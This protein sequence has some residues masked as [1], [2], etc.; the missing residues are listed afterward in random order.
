[1][2]KSLIL[3][4]ILFCTVVFAQKATLSADQVI[5]LVLKNKTKNYSKTALKSYQY[6]SYNK[7]VFSIDKTLIERKIDS[8]FEIKKSKKIFK[9]LDSTNYFFKKEMDKQHYYISE[10][11]AE[12]S[13]IDGREKENILAAKMAGFQEPI[14]EFLAL[15][16]TNISFY[17]N[18]FSLLGTNYVSPL[19]R[20]PFKDYQFSFDNY[21]DDDTKYIIKY[22]SINR[23][24]SIGL[25]GE[26]H[27]DKNTFALVRSKAKIIGKVNIFVVQNYEYLEN[28]NIWFP[29]KTT[30]FLRKGASKKSVK[31]FR[32]LIGYKTNYVSTKNINPEDVSYILINVNNFNVKINKPV[33][34]KKNDY[35]IEIPEG[36]IKRNSKN[37]AKFNVASKN[38][39]DLNTYIFLD[40]IVQEKHIERK[41]NILRKF[42]DAKYATKLL[43][44]N[45]SQIINFNNH[46]GFRLGFGGS[47]NDN[48]S[49]KF[50]LN[51]YIANGNKDKKLKYRYGADIQLL[52]KTNTW[53][54]GS[55]T[56]DIFETARSKLL[57]EEPNFA[58]INPRNLNISRFYSY[59]VSEVHIQHD[60]SPRLLSKLQFD[61]GS[62]LNE[63]DYTF[64]SQTKLLH[65]YNLSKLTLALQWTPF[66][67]YLRSPKG[68]FTVKKAYPK[69][70]AEFTKNFDNILA[71]D[72]DFT[73]IDLNI[74]YQIKTIKSGSTAF[75]LKA[76]Y[77]HG[78]APLSHL[79][80]VT[81]NHS[82]INPWRA[83]INFSGTNAFETMLFNEFISDKYISI[84]ARQNFEKFRVGKKFKPK[85]SIITRYA[86]GDIKN[87]EVH[88]EVSFKSMSKGFIE[89]GLVINQLFY[90]LGVSSFYRY[91]AYRFPKFEDNIAVKITYVIDLF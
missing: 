12:H 78:E 42:L 71:G 73:K 83:R 5:Q 3:L 87:R 14:Y 40:S 72:F 58:I 70:T 16:I 88:Q 11:I 79:Y 41:L 25:Q 39:K 63:F 77:V 55:F 15:G 57:F 24:K 62:Y 80:N 30:I 34:I 76:G 35:A 28:G 49:K 82:L 9:S 81:P 1:M 19:A 6:N 53:F 56:N 33:H 47:T 10:K 59:K 2:P 13:F 43:D 86:I 65:R 85:L 54:G 64:I 51:G 37:W 52:K 4:F 90:G 89:S 17:K 23:K 68:K 69:V 91:G 38:K 21:N 31:A 84:Q 60:I 20:K 74:E 61:A 44:I 29:K 22:K 48:L 8:I 67:K 26:L 75:L 36:A 32:R 7:L 46:E 27:I 50:R 45:L 66:N 18:T